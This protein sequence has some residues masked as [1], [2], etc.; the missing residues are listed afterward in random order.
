[1]AEVISPLSGNVWK[2]PVQVGDQVA[3]GDTVVIL[4]SMKM[5]IP[6]EAEEAGR[7][8]QVACEEGGSVTEGAVLVVLE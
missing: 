2:I 8:A 3:A 5:E 1:M 7:V 6:I 4:E